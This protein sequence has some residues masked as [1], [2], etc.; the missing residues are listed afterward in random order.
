MRFGTR[1]TFKSIQ[2]ARAAALLAG[3][4]FKNRDRVGGLVFGDIQREI[5]FF[6][7]AR[8]KNMMWQ[9]LKLLCQPSVEQPHP[10]ALAFALNQLKYN[11]SNGTLI[12]LLTDVDT[13]INTNLDLLATIKAKGDLVL[14]PI[15]DPID[16][17]LP[18]VNNITLV[19]AANNKVYLNNVSQT[20]S[21]NYNNQ[22]EANWNKLKNIVKKYQLKMITLHTNKA[23]YRSLNDGL[24]KLRH[25]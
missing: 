16:S 20:M 14:L 9:L 15:I 1:G 25:Y 3:T 6:P 13:I 10:I 2:A 12:F 18:M 23:V 8:H 21:K 22:W 4:G 7:P 24:K 17:N 11:L 5:E 19:N